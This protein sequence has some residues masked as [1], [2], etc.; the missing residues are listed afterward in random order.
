MEEFGLAVDPFGIA[1]SLTE[2][3]QGWMLHP[4]Q[5]F[6]AWGGLAGALMGAQLGWWLDL[7]QKRSHHSAAVAADER[8]ADPLWSELPAYGLMRDLYLTYTHWLEESLFGAPG[9]DPVTRR[10]A[11]FWARQWLNAVAPTNFL[12]LNPVA[13]KNAAASGGGSLSKGFEH[14]LEDMQAGD[15]PT[16]DKR[17]FQVGGNLANT[18]GAV[19][20]RNRLVEVIQYTPTQAKTRAIPIVL[21]APWINK[22]YILD[23]TESKSLV[24][25]LVDQGFD[26]FITSWKNPG[27]DLAD[28]TFEDYL[29]EGVLPA[30]NVARAICGAEAVHAAGY[31]LG[32]TALAAT[33]AWLNRSE[34]VKPVPVAHWTLLTTLTD[35]SRPGA[36][37]V[38]VDERSLS[39][40]DRKM[41]V[42]GFL[43]GRDV[44]R[45]FRF[46]R[47]NSLIWHFAV[48]RYLYGETLPAF[49]V[50]FWNADSTRM[51]RAMHRYYLRELYIR[52]RLVER[53][54]ITIAGWPIDLRRIRQ[55]LYMVGTEEDHIAPWKATFTL[56]GRIDAPVRY[57]LSSSGHILGIINPPAKSSKRAYFVG[58]AG[59]EDP[60]AWRLRQDKV[61]GSWWE[62]WVPW[63]AERCGPLRKAPGVG[64]SRFPKLDDA[65]GTYVHET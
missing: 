60:A 17:P 47:S 50:L 40:I 46:L 41:A 13:L 54:G 43:D 29:T 59:A 1:R 21:I 51:P 27:P 4:D 64:S 10:R 56:C 32:G 14:F 52:N 20:F 38:F 25:H 57:A 44:G 23:L 53:D 16:V 28:V 26:V 12:A 65:P 6:H 31:C 2:A 5:L 34:T 58:P 49:D 48:N 30:I 22:Y 37:E 39:H 8:F 7:G 36:I 19:V 45:A 24:R 9:V 55:P 35:F 3:A 42:Q 15:L 18:P 62:D 61:P 63:L 11:A 33:M